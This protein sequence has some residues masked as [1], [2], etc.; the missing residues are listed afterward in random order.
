MTV[1]GVQDASGEEVMFLRVWGPALLCLGLA[2]LSG[3]ENLT[4]VSG[5]LTVKITVIH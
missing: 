1:S 3:N 5:G 2:C 4:L